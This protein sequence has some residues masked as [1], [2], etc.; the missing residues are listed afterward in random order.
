MARRQVAVGRT[1]G[2]ARAVAVDAYCRERDIHFVLADVQGV[3]AWTFVDL[4]PAFSVGDANGEA[5]TRTLIEGIEP[6][7]EAE[8]GHERALVTCARDKRH[9]LAD[10]DSVA[11]AELGGAL[12]AVLNGSTACVKVLDARVERDGDVRAPQHAR[13]WITLDS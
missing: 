12:G 10:G 2:L 7:P 13:I 5:P 4:G 9:N 3:F 1:M 11:L 8:A 6:L